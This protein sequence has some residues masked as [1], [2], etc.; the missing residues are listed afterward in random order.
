MTPCLYYSLVFHLLC[1]HLPLF[2]Q[3]SD[4]IVYWISYSYTEN[5]I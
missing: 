3:I 1:Q 2:M 5:T 4:G